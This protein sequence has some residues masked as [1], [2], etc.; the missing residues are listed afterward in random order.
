MQG[1]VAPPSRT[2]EHAR[3]AQVDAWTTVGAHHRHATCTSEQVHVSDSAVDGGGGRLTSVTDRHEL[4]DFLCDALLKETEFEVQHSSMVILTSQVMIKPK[5]D[6][7][8]FEYE[9]IPIPRR[10]AKG[11]SD[12]MARVS[13][14]VAR[15]PCSPPD[16]F[17]LRS[18]CVDR[19]GTVRPRTSNS[20]VSS[21]SHS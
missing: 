21:A 12:A 13:L 10:S 17:D 19:N 3:G 2:T 16:A 8:L 7:Q 6:H 15:A 5:A 1:S 18:V 9:T 14:V 4:D 20:I 11:G